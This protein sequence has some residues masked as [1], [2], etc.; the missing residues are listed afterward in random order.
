MM[1][2]EGG[3]S[4][5]MKNFLVPSSLMWSELSFVQTSL[6]KNKDNRTR[7]NATQR[8]RCVAR[9]GVMR[10]KSHRERVFHKNFLLALVLDLAQRENDKLM[11]LG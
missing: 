3:T 11:E 5:L 8:A 4:E 2:Q 7:S 6:E 9:N 1:W 10:L